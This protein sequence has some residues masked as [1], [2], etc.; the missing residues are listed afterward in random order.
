MKSRFLLP[1]LT[2]FLAIPW[3]AMAAQETKT[4][5]EQAMPD[6]MTHLVKAP[7]IDFEN[8]RDPFISH[9][10]VEKRLQQ[11]AQ[12]RM[13]QKVENEFASIG[14]D[15]QKELLENFDLT[16]LKLVATMKKGNDFVA[17]VEDATGNGYVVRKGQYIGKNNG[18]I[19]NIDNSTVYI[20]EPTLNPVGEI[21]NLEVKLTLNE[22]SQ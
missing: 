1:A 17:M 8:L 4:A 16:S 6:A 14:S 5:E 13:K 22:V 2:F 3:L 15:R 18:I 9:L 20:T 7:E 12:L 19:N 11:Q 21:E 10:T